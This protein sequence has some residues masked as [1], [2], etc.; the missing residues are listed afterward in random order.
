MIEHDK[1]LF[2]SFRKSKIKYKKIYTNDDVV[3][4]LQILVK[5]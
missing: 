4:Q 2:N 3:K 5:R 1:E